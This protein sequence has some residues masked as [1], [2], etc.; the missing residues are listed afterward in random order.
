[1]AT[2]QSSAEQKPGLLRF[3]RNDEIQTTF[4]P[5]G[6]RRAILAEQRTRLKVKNET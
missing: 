3:A 5:L 4:T 6:G 1:M 2:K